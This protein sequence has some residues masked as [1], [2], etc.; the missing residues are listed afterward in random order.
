MDK[1]RVWLF[2][3]KSIN[4]WSKRQTFSQG[5]NVHLCHV[6]CIR[7]LHVTPR[8]KSNRMN[9]EFQKINH[10]SDSC[11]VHPHT[12]FVHAHVPLLNCLA[13]L[14]GPSQTPH[15]SQ[16]TPASPGS[17]PKSHTLTAA[18]RHA[19]DPTSSGVPPPLP[20]PVDVDVLELE[21]ELF[22]CDVL[23]EVSEADAGT[24]VV[25]TSAT[26]VVVG[27]GVTVIGTTV[28]VEVVAAA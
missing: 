10:R 1:A 28:V 8:S 23:L 12:G 22:V 14:N 5:R 6:V 24:T 3:L 2:V 19:E 17:K 16:V 26:L 21:V 9:L 4:T 27:S 7:M 25:S 13:G 15:R 18:S 20:L 11:I